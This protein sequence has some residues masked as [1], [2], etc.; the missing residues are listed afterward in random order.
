MK[1]HRPNRTKLQRAIKRRDKRRRNWCHR[2]QFCAP[3][4]RC[5]DS[6]LRSGR[7]GDWVYYLLP[8]NKQCRRRWVRPKDPGTSAQRQNRARLAAASRRYSAGL[9]KRQRA[10]CI[11][12]GA[13]RQSRPRLG[14]SGP[15]TGQQ[16]L[17]RKQYAANARAK[18]QNTRIPAKV[19][20]P[21]KV[22]KPTWGTLRGNAVVP[23]EQRRQEAGPVRNVRVGMKN[24][25]CGMQKTSSASH[26]QRI[27]RVT[28][29]RRV[30]CR[31]TARV[32]PLRVARHSGSFPISGK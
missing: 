13:R 14:Q 27:K 7:C 4:G 18:S 8:G 28:G 23:P 2:C 20:E 30:Q 1:A 29:T 31:R 5:L 3:S 16:Y 25:K 26:M 22:A 6:T 19:S 11:A 21:K 15:L 32:T 17:V 10:A 9:T 24:V 12:A